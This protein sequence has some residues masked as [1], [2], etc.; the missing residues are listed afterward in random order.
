MRKISGTENAPVNR[1]AYVTIQTPQCFLLNQ[2][3]DAYAKKTQLNFT[4]DATLFESF[5]HHINLVE[6]ER[7]NFKI[8]VSEDLLLANAL[9]K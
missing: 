2:I 9:L 8:T 1:D 6:G 4:D 7:R 3:K 5:G